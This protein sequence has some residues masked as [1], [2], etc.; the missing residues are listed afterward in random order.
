MNITVFGGSQPREG[1]SAF[2]E[3]LLLGR[4]LAQ[5]GHTVLTGGY[6][7][8]MEAVSRGAQEAGGHVIG[9]TCE[10]IENWRKVAPN[11]WVKEEWR[12]KTLIE[13]LQALIEGCDAA[14]ALPGGPG[15]LTEIALTWNLMIVESLHRR[16]LILIGDGWQ[17][18]F[19]QV[20]TKLDG[21]TPA[22]QRELLSFAPDVQTAVKQLESWK[23]AG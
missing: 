19:D 23:V 2:E 14:L 6:I 1:E 3:A 15:T 18:V 22:H 8:T 13:R 20:F 11:R 16:P 17:S 10:E 4:L 21:Y 12:K 9:V 7:G 5:R